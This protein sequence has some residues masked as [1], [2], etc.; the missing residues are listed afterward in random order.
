[1]HFVHEL[2]AL[3]KTTHPFVKNNTLNEFHAI[4]FKIS[5]LGLSTKGF[6]AL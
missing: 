4:C 5:W 3:F 2:E 1:M 6:N